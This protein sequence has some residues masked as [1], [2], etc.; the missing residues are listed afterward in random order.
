MLEVHVHKHEKNKLVPVLMAP[1]IPQICHQMTAVDNRK[2][3]TQEKILPSFEASRV[4]FQSIHEA[5]VCASLLRS[6][7]NQFVFPPELCGK[8]VTTAFLAV[9][10]R[11]EEEPPSLM[12]QLWE[13]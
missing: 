4:T 7:S 12:K 6:L 9:L 1:A 11:W 2:A 5:C 8:R 10:P 3:R 13:T